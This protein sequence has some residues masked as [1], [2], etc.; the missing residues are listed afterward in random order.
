MSRSG[1][2]EDALTCFEHRLDDLLETRQLA[3]PPGERPAVVA[4]GGRMVADLLQRGD[5]R[6][7]SSLLHF[8]DLGRVGDVLHQ[9]VE[10]RLIQPDLLGGHRAVIELVDL[11]GKLGR[12]LGLGLGAPE[13]QQ[14]VQ[15]AQRRSPS[16]DICE[17]N[18]GREPTRPGLVKSRI[19]HRSPSPFSI[20][21]P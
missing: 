20:G 8:A 17:M 1:E 16:P 14:P 7:H 15:R 4:I 9:L 12:D 19:D 18:D 10:H 13:Q 5:G 6:Q 2:H 3:G 21:V 11:V